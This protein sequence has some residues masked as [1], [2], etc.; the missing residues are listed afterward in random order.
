M[1]FDTEGKTDDKADALSAKY[2][3]ELKAKARIVRR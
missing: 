2:I 3:G 1:V